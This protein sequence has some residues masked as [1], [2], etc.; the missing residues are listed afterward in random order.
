MDKYIGV[1]LIEATPCGE[2]GFHIAQAAKAAHEANRE[3]CQSIG[4]DSQPPWD[5]APEW[6]KASV[7]DGV[8]MVVHGN[9]SPVQSHENWLRHKQETGWKYGPVKDP[10]KKEHPCMVPYDQLPGEQKKKDSIFVNTVRAYWSTHNI[11]SPQHERMGYLVKY[12]DGYESWSP[13]NVFEAAYFRLENPNRITEA[14]VERFAGRPTLQRID[15]KTA[16]VSVTTQTG[17]VQHEA[18]SCVDPD[19]YDEEIGKKVGYER[20]KSSLWFAMGFVLQWATN[21]LSPEDGRDNAAAG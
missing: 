9:N 19:N 8:S 11:P 17:F 13:N 20:I 6:Q 7:I 2:L 4:D 1:K 12:P 21:G 3:Y 5:E 16:L 15:P 10:E 18:S 14:D